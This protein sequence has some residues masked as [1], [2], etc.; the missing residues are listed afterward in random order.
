MK[1]FIQ[2]H[3]CANYLVILHQIFHQT[4]A[5]RNTGGPY[6]LKTQSNILMNLL[7]V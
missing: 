1:H 2:A 6:L 3:F 4:L 5:D 7:P